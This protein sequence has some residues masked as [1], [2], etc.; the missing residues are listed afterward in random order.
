MTAKR[1]ECLMPQN[2]SLLLNK[3]YPWK[4]GEKL[5]KNN[6]LARV[7]NEN[8]IIDANTLK[9]LA[10]RRKNK[11]KSSELLSFT[12]KTMR[13]LI[14]NHGGESVLDFSI[15][16]H[17]YWGFPII[18]GSAIK[19]VTRSYCDKFNKLSPSEILGWF[20]NEPAKAEEQQEGS[21][22]FMEAW[23]NK[24]NGLNSFS[25]YIDTV[26]YKNYYE[27]KGYPDDRAN[28]VPIKYIGVKPE[29]EFEFLIAI[30]PLNPGNIK[31]TDFPKIQ[32]LITETLVTWGIGAKTSSDMG[33]FINPRLE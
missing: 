7:I 10:A 23:P 21:L 3:H 19:G 5:N 18:P 16:M 32:E 29:T 30:S 6:V 13:P 1:G 25:D 14:V 20:G 2:R 12:L 28:P 31:N 9:R 27:N 4:I 22:I 33:Y 24:E 11:F 17:P 26:H 8:T 15:A